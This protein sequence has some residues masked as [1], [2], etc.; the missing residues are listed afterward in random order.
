MV[1]DDKYK[2]AWKTYDFNSGYFMA[3]QVNGVN[4]E[5]LRKHLIEK[6][7]IGT[8]ALNDTDIRVAFS[9]IEK[10]DIPHVFDSIAKGIADLKA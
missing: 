10:D 2:D 4:A 7:S 5:T 1:Y 9:C 6:Y 3:I 8:I